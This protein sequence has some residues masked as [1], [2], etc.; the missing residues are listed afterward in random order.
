M[1]SSLRNRNYRLFA[2]GQ[3]VSNS[4]T[5]MQRTAQDW[6]VL[7]LSH[8]SGS[9]LGIAAGLQFLPLLLFSLWGGAIADR[10]GKRRILLITQSLMG[11]LAL[12]LGILAVTGTVRLWHVYLLAFALGMIT[13]VDN[14]TRQTFVTEVV[15][16]TDM[17]NA[18]ALN[19]AIFNLARIAGPA[20]AGIIIGLVGTPT[21]FLINAVSYGAVITGLLL[22]R[23]GELSPVKRTARAAGQ[24]REA[25]RYLKGSPR[26]WLPLTMLFFVAT[27]G[28]NFQVTTALMSRGVFHTGAGAFGLASTAYAVGALGGALLAARRRH[29]SVRLQ[30][31]VALAFGILETASG[32]MPAYWAFLLLLLPTGLAVVMYTTAA[33]SAIQL[34]TDPQLRGRVMGVYMLVFLGG[35]PIG[36]PLIGWVAEQFGPRM[37]LISG[38][39]ISAI[40]A[41]AVGI[42][43]I[44]VTGTSVRDGLRPLR[45]K[46]LPMSA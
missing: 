41:I 22:M 10:F 31:A 19:S 16:R 28:M 13:V 42:V 5:W 45:R 36:S 11:A 27:F 26:I 44:R 18:I 38:G 35:A 14:P 20:M 7:D 40:A 39:V 37:S 9:A 29:P 4:G 17:A 21:A 3:V 24:L 30:I 25:L 33:N 8:G 32:L 12:I 43:L 46:L 23:S 15:G 6:L 2:A 1:F 34:G